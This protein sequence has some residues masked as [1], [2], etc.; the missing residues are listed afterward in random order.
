MKLT[1]KHKANFRVCIIIR[2][3]YQSNKIK[4]NSEVIFEMV[5]DNWN[6]LVISIYNKLL[7]AVRSKFIY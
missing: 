5:K 4:D 2:V 1:N 6:E 3:T 7:P